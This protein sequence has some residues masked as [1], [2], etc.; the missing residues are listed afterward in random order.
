MPTTL[1]A[2]PERELLSA[3]HHLPELLRQ[4]LLI[5]DGAMGTMIQRHPLT[6]ED[7]RGARFADH[8]KP[9]RGNNDLL[10]LTRPDIIKGIHAEYF[11]AGAD[12]VETNTFSG[13]SI[14]QADYGL[15][16]VVYE[17]NY[18]SAR[19]AREAADEYST[20]DK[21]RFVAGAVGPTNR[22]ASLSPDVN[23]P[24]YRAV[25]FDELAAAY[26]EQVRGLIDGG[27][28]ALLIETIFDTL[29]AKAALYAVQKFFDEGGREVPLMISGTITDASGRTLSGQTVEAFWNSIRHL[30]LLSVGLNC[31]LGASQLKQY[32]EELSRISDV[33]ISAYPNA[34][35]PNAFG[36][37]DESAQEFA[38]LVEDYLKD[39]IVTVVGGCCGTTPQHIAELSRLAE[40]YKPRAL[41]GKELKIKNE[42]LKTGTV[43]PQSV[44]DFNSSFLIFNSTGTRLAGLEPFNITPSSLFVNVGERCNVTGSRAFARLIRTG[45]YEEALAVARVQ[46]EEGAQ[47][48]D[49]NMDEGMLDSEQA[50]TTFLHLI[51]SEPDIARVPVMID[52][53]KWSVLEAGLKCVQGKSI[54]NS[55]SLKEGEEVFLQR[56]RT[57]RQYGAAMVVM[58]FDEQGQA[59][60]LARRKE[61]CQR[62]YDLLMS[63]NFPAEDII[64][65]P[66]ILIVGT[67]MEEHRNY[68]ID[69]IES[70]RW[71]KAHLPGA[72]TSGGVSNISFSFRGNEVVREAMHAAFLYHAIR[73]GLDMGIVNPNQLAV[74]DEV[75]KDLLELVEDVL[76]NRRDDATE[77]LL[78]F[79]DTVKQKGKVEVVADAWRSLPVQERLS[80]ALVKGIT[81]FIDEDTEAA[82]QELARPL[83]VIEG[84]L[85]AGMNVVG[86]LFGAGK[87]FLPQVVK[88]ARVMKKAVAYLE[89]YLLA[90]KQGSDRQTAGKILMAT[91]KGDVHDIGKNIVGVVL[92]CNNFDIVDLGVMVPL[93]RI[94]DEAQRQQV[95]VIGLS[96]LIT[97]SLDEMVYVAQAM[98]KRGMTTPLLI[99]G[100][101]TSRLHTAVRIAPAYSG[102]VVHV[103]DASRSVGVAAGLLGSGEAAYAQT[104]A[105][106]YA[107]LRADYASRQRDKSYLTIE[108]ARENGFKSDWA[109]TAITKPTFLGTQVLADYDLAELARYIDWTPFFHTWELKGRYPR[110]L[111]DENLGEAATKLFADAQ[112]LLQRI[113]DGKLLTARAVLG[114][115]PANT[116]DYDTIEVYT[117]DRR[118]TVATEF[119]TLR[120]QGEKGPNIPN[121]AFSD[122]LAPKASGRADYLGGFAVTAGIGIEKLLDQFAA[123]HDD[124][125]SIMVKALAD[126][127]AEAF[128]ERLHERVRREF[129]GYAPDEHL[130]GDD[131]IQEKYRGVRPAPGYPGCPDHT[132]KITLFQLLDAEGNTGISLTENLAMYPASSV[133]GMYYAH[134]DARYFGLGRIGVDQVADI[135][136]RKAMELHEL[137]RWLMPNLNYEPK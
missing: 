34:G 73:A 56:A 69:F 135:A 3:R 78:E 45:A 1:P 17:L 88:S 38:A 39:G 24:G 23:R 12:M 31:A 49:I 44:Q 82:R 110:I 68:A 72:L 96:G 97:P 8:A 109:T 89:P 15:E 127:L 2:A 21:P 30:P 129:W 62:S 86:D 13:T 124:Y 59:D 28:D 25:T 123:D 117:D 5:L 92:A 137:E 131:L 90:D 122:F 50:M 35:L 107:A 43:A 84:P 63:I 87:M 22:T 54:V 27:V 80:H 33:H 61:I 19:L 118:D 41:P 100:A 75:P 71:I 76:L 77:R 85:M 115:W 57:V 10:S 67:G 64:F 104:V 52:S 93:E 65:D 121:L 16:H 103:N 134:P 20:P 9:L 4:R 29:N 116:V 105:D 99:G 32:V 48:L 101:T 91:V 60:T 51:A 46:V 26:L 108:A 113:I 74:Y 83:D 36:G 112:A 120:Q 70:V 94:L 128:A 53:S 119:F 6:E 47:V 136:R 102:P 79:A 126:R 14:A 130:T 58:A 42:E 106:D 81:E 37:Y 114:F 40:Q 55:I 111:T 66:N 18:E 98:Q 11:A 133:S 125:S 7:F 132:E 95:D